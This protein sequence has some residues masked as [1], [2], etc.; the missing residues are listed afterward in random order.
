MIY[1]STLNSQII[2]P[3]IRSQ[4]AVIYDC[5]NEMIL[6]SKRGDQK[7]HPASTTKIA[8]LLY[9]L[10]CKRN[11]KE[12][13][14]VLPE[15][16]KSMPKEQKINLNYAV[17]PYLL[18]PDA[19][20]IGLAQSS[21]YTV[22]DL[23]YALMLVSANDAANVLAYHL[24]EQ[25]IEQ[26]MIGLNQ[27]INS[28]GCKDTTY[29]NPSGLEYPAHRTTAVDLAKMLSHG[30]KEPDFLKIVST[31]FYKIESGELLDRELNNSNR[32]LRT[33]SGLQYK[34]CIGGK[35]GYT[36]HAGYC[37]VGAAKNSERTLIVAVMQSPT[38][39][40]RF[41][42]ATNL[43][44]AAFSEKRILR[45]FYNAHDPCFSLLPKYANHP[46]F[47]STIEDCKI[48]SFASLVENLEPKVQFF[49]ATLPIK[50]G[51][52]LGRV[53]IVAANG[54]VVDS[55]SLVAVTGMSHTWLS[56]WVQERGRL[57]LL[58]LTAF[59]LKMLFR[60]PKVK[61]KRG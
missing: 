6:F 50:K 13:V 48:E 21:Y 39:Q 42:D 14:L 45:V 41:I 20:T 54:K 26:F 37:F 40:D 57:G 28:I 19:Y 24:G 44:N 58:M 8:T 15:L 11:S 2:A 3:K 29:V 55:K 10:Q 61:E 9:A 35:T 34:Y 51:Q 5:D 38:A 1:F 36:E 25:S 31:A 33:E 7:I 49:E 23:Y 53:D 43:F 17:P 22:E 56:F 30:I 32:L 59:T 18:E 16:L 60:A 12:L 46:V 27:F 47:L 4:V 52:I